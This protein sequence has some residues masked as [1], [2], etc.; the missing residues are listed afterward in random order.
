MSALTTR[1]V[2]YTLGTGTITASTSSTAVTGSGTSFTVE[3]VVGYI[4]KNSSGTNIGTVAS[5]TDDTNLTL[6][7]NAASNLTAATFNIFNPQVSVVNIPLT[8]VQVDNNFIQLNNYKLERSK[9]LSDL[10]NKS[11]ARTNLGVAIGTNVQAYDA[12][13]TSLSA[14]STTGIVVRS[15]TDTFTTR[16]LVAT[17]NDIDITNSS[18]LAGNI[19]LSVGSNIAKLDRSSNIFSGDITA[20]N[21]NATSDLQ[22]KNNVNSI[23][24]A[25][26]TVNKMN[27]VSFKWNTTGK[28]SYGVIAQE[29]EK[30]LPELVDVKDNVKSVNYLGLIAFLI[31]AVKELDKRVKDLESK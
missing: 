8:N 11:T 30:F 28:N 12:D 19:T 6:V 5:I 22:F 2:E 14:L 10:P 25:L 20:A 29:L 18:G 24:N 1:T 26:E 21:F 17:A 3:L 23:N 7:A 27:G 9:N 13:L 16:S 15:A 31:N 4:I